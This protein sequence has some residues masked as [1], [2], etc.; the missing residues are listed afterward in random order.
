MARRLSPAALAAEAG[1]AT[2]RID[3]LVRI[4]ALV[5]LDD[6]SFTAADVQRVRVIDAY[7]AGGIGLE[8]LATAIERR[9]TTLE[10]VQDLYPEPA[11]RSE[12]TYDEFRA[13]LGGDAAGGDR[14]ARLDA[15]LAAFGLPVPDGDAR[16]TTQDEQMLGT[17]IQVWDVGAD[18]S[19]PVRAA[20]LAGE[21]MRRLVE[22]WLQLFH[23]QVSRPLEDRTR[24]VDEVEPLILGPAARIVREVPD[25]LVW[26]FERHFESGMNELNTMAMETGLAR[27]GMLPRPSARPPAIAFADLAGY[28]RLTQERGDEL[29]AA[30]AALLGDLAAGVA[31]THGGRLVKLLG[32]GAMLHFPRA[33]GAVAASL[34]L[35]ARIADA[36][37]PAAHVGVNAGPVIGRDGDYFGHT[38][39]VAARLAA[40]APAGS[41]LVTRAV[42]E[43]VAGDGGDGMAGLRFEPV[44]ELDLRNVRDP[45]AAFRAVREPAVSA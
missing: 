24:T 23:E 2:A 29:A 27:E 4:G 37:L 31:R 9:W 44:G 3:A 10:H 13:E 39:N 5:P 21:S 40:Q 6:G 30:S 38:V 1:T 11:A 25:L 45:I 18:G 28:T 16:L 26:L 8:L 35:V 14:A 7:E 32:D 41:V 43:A 20:R 34:E 42:V 36:G 19:M 22:G 15:V 12:R 33:E 17:F